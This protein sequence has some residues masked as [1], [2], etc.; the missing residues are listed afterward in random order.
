MRFLDRDDAGG[1]LALRLQHYA[2]RPDIVVLGLPRGGVPVAA[3]IA[4][5]LRAPLDVFLVRKLGVPGHEELAMGAIAEGGVIVLNQDVVASL[6]IPPGAIEGVQARERRELER[7]QQV[8][9]GV[10]G[11]QNVQGKVVI[12]IDDG[13]ATGSTMEAAIVALR[14]L[15]PSRIVAATPVGARESCDR[16]AEIADEVVC[17]LVPERFS[18]VGQWYDDFSETTDDEVTRL[19]DAGRRTDRPDPA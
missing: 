10:T 19:I 16:I 2:G 1:Q 11:A 18:A 7:R 17:A 12:L 5:A 6:G 14:A 8:Y 13:L 3:R 4:A 9:R 15:G